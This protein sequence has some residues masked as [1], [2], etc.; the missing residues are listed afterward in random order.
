LLNTALN[1]ARASGVDGVWLATNAQNTPAIDYYLAKGFAQ[2]GHTHFTVQDQA[3]LNNVYAY[4][5]G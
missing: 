4:R 5:F 3:Y 1:A 2:V